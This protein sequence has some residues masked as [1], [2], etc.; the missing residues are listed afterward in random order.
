LWS[1]LNPRACDRFGRELRPQREL[2]RKFVRRQFW[3]SLPLYDVNLAPNS[4]GVREISASAL[5]S[6]VVGRAELRRRWSFVAGLNRRAAT[7]SVANCDV[8]SSFL[9]NSTTSV[10][11]L[12]TTSIWPLTCFRGSYRRSRISPPSRRDSASRYGCSSAST[13]SFIAASTTSLTLAR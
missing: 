6:A 8:S 1:H 13:S 12:S 4:Y 3:I 11:D 2:S 7:V 10:L 5:S 9:E